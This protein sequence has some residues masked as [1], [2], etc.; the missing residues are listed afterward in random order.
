MAGKHR[1]NPLLLLLALCV[2]VTLSAQHYRVD[3]EGEGTPA[4]EIHYYPGEILRDTYTDHAAVSFANCFSIKYYDEDEVTDLTI[5]YAKGEASNFNLPILKTDSTYTPKPA[6]VK[7]DNHY[8]NR[9]FCGYFFYPYLK[10]GLAPGIYRDTLLVQGQF[11]GYPITFS[12]FVEQRVAHYSEVYIDKG[13]S[14]TFDGQPRTQSGRYLTETELLDLY[15]VEPCEVHIEASQTFVTQ[16]SDVQLTADRDGDYY[17]WTGYGLNDPTVKN[18][19]ATID[20]DGEKEYKMEL[21]AFTETGPNLAQNGSFEFGYTGFE[22]DYEAVYPQRFISD[23]P[24]YIP[25]GGHYSLVAYPQQINGPWATCRYDGYMMV[26]DGGWQPTQ[27][28]FASTVSV[29]PHTWYAFSVDVASV[30]NIQNVS[31]QPLL[32]FYINGETLGELH[33]PETT[34]CDWKK[35]YQIWYSDEVSGEIQIILRNTQTASG[36]NDFAIDNLSFRELCRAY[37]ELTIKANFSAAP[38][39]QVHIVPSQTELCGTGDV[40]LTTDIEADYYLWNGYGINDPT[41]REPVATFDQEGDDTYEVTIRSY[42]EYGDNV[43]ANGDFEQGNTGFYSDY[44]YI[45]PYENLPP[46]GERINPG[47]YSVVSCPRQVNSPWARCTYDG[48]MMVVDGAS[49][50]KN[51][52]VFRTEVDVQTDTWYAFS[53]EVS[54]ISNSPTIAD[55]ASLQFYING[56]TF[57]QIHHPDTAIIQGNHGYYYTTCRWKKIYQLWYSG[58]NTHIAISLQ[59]YNQ[60][61]GSNDFAVDNLR[62]MPLCEATDTVHIRLTTAP[63]CQVHILPSQTELCGTGDVQLTTDIEADYY[64]WNGYGINDPTIREPVATFDQSGDYTYDV[65]IKSYTEYGDNLIVNGDFEQGNTGFTTDYTWMEPNEVNPG[66]ANRHINPGKYSIV[67]YPLQVNWPWARCTYDGKMM[68]VDGKNDSKNNDVFRTEVDVLPNRWYAFSCEVSTISHAP[69]ISSVAS[70]QFYING[71]TFS[72]IHHPDTMMGQGGGAYTVCRWKKIYQLWYSDNNDHI[73]I[74]LQDHNGVGGGN[75]FAVDNLRFLPVCE[76]TDTV[77]IHVN[78]VADE[79]KEQTVTACSSYTWHDKV[80]TESGNYT[81]EAKTDAGC[82]IREELHLTVGYPKHVALTHTA[83]DSYTWHGTT[84]TESGVYEY[85]TQTVLGCDSIE[86]LSLTIAESYLFHETATACD[87]Y[88]WQGETYTASGEYQKDYQ[89]VYGCDSVYTLSLTVN[90]SGTGEEEMVEYKE[91]EWK[92]QN[93]TASGDY[94]FDTITTTGCDS[95]V[96]L[97][98]TIVDT[99]FVASLL[100]VADLCADDYHVALEYALT[101][102]ILP[103]QRVDV[104]F[105][106]DKFTP[107]QTDDVSGAVLIPLPDSIR[108][109]YYDGLLHIRYKSYVQDMPFSFLVRYPSSV[110][111]Q[112]WNNVLA[113]KNSRYNGGYLWDAYR[114]YVDNVEMV[115][116]VQSF[117][118]CGEGKIL[119]MGHPYHALLRRVGEDYFI[120]TCPLIPVPHEDVQPIPTIYQSGQRVSVRKEGQDIPVTF[121]DVLGNVITSGTDIIAPEVPG[122]YLMEVDGQILKTVIR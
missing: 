120:P 77:H 16:A 102:V 44:K 53:C 82:D 28:V 10:T 23:G 56:E 5:A 92:G 13:E 109:D 96:T 31:T 59:N 50:G 78:A 112:K 104:T 30:S 121:Y 68:V 32:Q 11:K 101:N 6:I 71:V 97:H 75:D 99:P 51:T 117:I 72:E 54:S 114:W 55:V 69:S 88:T 80:Y 73:V 2:S 27:S 79:P 81:Y 45:E 48:Q 3:Y 9:K 111:G 22:T 1:Y 4:F 91:Y 94:A 7:L 52:D 108:P 43:I 21:T 119:Q 116:E 40:Q 46:L 118:Y 70:L 63:D 85:K 17:Q 26:V 49:S 34:Q 100:P 84:Y 41:I 105:T 76:A 47:Q 33:R 86:T 8:N 90:H 64:L 74:S 62:F 65:T 103:P 107:V 36:G 42:T 93:Y 12:F 57:T 122:V 87:S 37:D 66:N 25:G 38:D 95:L 14:Y 83:C 110:I 24:V 29:E 98:L 115:G 113:L 106:N 18:P 58:S 35:I 19:V 61:S 39:C 67:D 89:S 15:V 20:T 60:A